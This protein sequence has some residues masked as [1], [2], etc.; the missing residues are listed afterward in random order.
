KGIASLDDLL[1]KEV[2]IAQANPDAAAV[3]KLTREALTRSGHWEALHKRTLVYKGTVND[4]A[5]DIKVG[6]VDAGIVWDATVK[7]YP[8]LEA[9]ALPSL[10]ETQGHISVAVLRDCTQPAAALRFARFLAARD[11]GLPGFEQHGV[12][13]AEGDVW[14][15]EP[16]LRLLSGAMLRPAI[17]ETLTAFERREGVRVTRVYNGCGILVA[18]MLAG[19]RPDAYFAC[20]KS[21]MDQVNDLFMDNV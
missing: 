11:R 14:P 8:E 10:S 9:I 20:D 1:Q 18:Q 5:N 4:V 13:P 16:E 12:R 7:S 3:G 21:F 19:E 6:T 15:E 17:E 2:R